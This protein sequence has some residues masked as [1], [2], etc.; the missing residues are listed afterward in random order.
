MTPRTLAIAAAALAAL[1][2]AGW[3]TPAGMA[4]Q[5]ATTGTGDRESGM[6]LLVTGSRTWTDAAYI[7]QILDDLLGTHRAIILYHGA[8][9]T[10]ADHIADEWATER[11]ANGGNVLIQRIP[12][13][14]QNSKGEFDRSAGM[15]RNAEL[16]AA[17]GTGGAVACHAFI[18]D[19]SRGASHCAKLARRAGIPVQV[20]V[21]EERTS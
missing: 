11:Q 8:C 5:T 16:V 12:A 19:N 18:R 6:R 10:G 7:R 14:W 17:V 1:A 13:R 21:W 15:H 2:A 4:T 3:W 20:H 9:P